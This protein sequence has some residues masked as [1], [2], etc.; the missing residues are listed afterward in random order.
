MEMGFEVYSTEHFHFSVFGRRLNIFLQILDILGCPGFKPRH[1]VC[2]AD[3]INTD[4][5]NDVQV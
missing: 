4:E 5:G 1:G 2:S 3:V